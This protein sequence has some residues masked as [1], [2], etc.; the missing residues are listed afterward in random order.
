MNY[1]TAEHQHHCFCGGGD[2]GE[3]MSGNGKASFDW[4]DADQLGGL[5]KCRCHWK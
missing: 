3:T 4:I 1:S 5:V 2:L